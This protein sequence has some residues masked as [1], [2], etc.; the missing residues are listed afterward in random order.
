MLQSVIYLVD[1]ANPLTNE[2]ELPG[3][4]LFS[5]GSLLVNV[6]IGLLT[7]PEIIGSIASTVKG[8]FS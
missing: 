4:E 7:S 6:G 1:V 2:A 5:F 3:L 8:W